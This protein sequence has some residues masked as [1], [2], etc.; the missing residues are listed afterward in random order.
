[1]RLRLEMIADATLHVP[2]LIVLQPGGSARRPPQAHSCSP[3]SQVWCYMTADKASP[4]TKFRSWSLCQKVLLQVI[5]ILDR[6]YRALDSLAIKHDLFKVETI[7][8]TH[9]VV[10][11]LQSPKPDHAAKAAWFALDAHRAARSIPISAQDPSLGWAVPLRFPW[12]CLCCQYA[13]AECWP[14]HAASFCS[15]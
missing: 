7:A 5:E 13:S 8:S 15:A 2:Q 11:N 4:N 12:L 10:G 3:T 6:L 1:M 14:D 9:M